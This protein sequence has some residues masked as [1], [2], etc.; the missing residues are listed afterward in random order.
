MMPAILLVLLLCGSAP[1]GPGA[2]KVELAR[3]QAAGGCYRLTIQKPLE[4]EQFQSVAD[5]LYFAIADCADPAGEIWAGVVSEKPE[6]EQ[7]T[8]AY[9]LPPKGSRPWTFLVGGPTI[10]GTKVCVF[11]VPRKAS[12]EI[13]WDG[14]LTWEVS[15]WACLRLPKKLSASCDYQTAT[16][17]WLDS[18]EL[19]VRLSTLDAAEDCSFRA[20]LVPP[21]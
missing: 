9:L 7:P 17:A 3:A 13:D 20:E 21:S 5:D 19:Q 6:L 12:G 4:G 10:A 16:L 1:A 14:G 15:P 18:W 11:A 2:A 8:L